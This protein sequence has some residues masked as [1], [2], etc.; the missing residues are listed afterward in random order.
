MSDINAAIGLAQLESFSRLA[1]A[2]RQIAK[3]YDR[4]LAPFQKIQLAQ[5]DYEQIVPFMYVIRVPRDQRDGLKY[6]LQERG[7]HADLRYSPCHRERIF[8][9]RNKLLPVTEW[10][11]AELI[12]LPLFPGMRTEDI[13]NVVQQIEEYFR[14]HK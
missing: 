12:S 7:I 10:I 2:R 14:S 8:G 13:A 11:T 5:R 3:D 6:H 1:Q 9:E 4:M